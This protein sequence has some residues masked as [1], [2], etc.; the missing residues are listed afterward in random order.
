MLHGH[1]EYHLLR[2]AEVIEETADSRSFVLEIP[3]ALAES[4][5]YAAGQFCTF[6]ATIDGAEVVRSY[7]MSSSPDVDEP[8]TTTVKRVP[9][10]LM[11]NWMIDKVG[12]G[13]E[14][15][16]MRPAGLFTLGDHETP[17]VCFAGGSGIT[18]VISVI[19]SALAKTSRLISLIYANRSREQVIFSKGLEELEQR[20]G[21]RLRLHHHLDQATGFLDE[22]ACVELIGE[23][24]DADFYVCGPTP[25]MDTVESALEQVGIS[26]GQLFIERFAAPAEVVALNE[27]S[28]TERVTFKIE[29]KKKTVDYR[30]GDT[31]LETARRSGGRPPSSCE[32]GNCG[33]CMALVEKGVATMR[34]NNALTP[35]E[36]E[37]GW[38]L[39]CQAIPSS[40]EI[41]VN[42][43]A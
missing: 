8:L 2:V 11:S 18:P 24:R 30:L 1:E 31:L 32:A 6:R 29:R 21:G 39:T 16:V 20:A 27:A 19:K 13:D 4:F 28:A 43:D 7:S 3:A 23:Q 14:L 12:V 40:L 26:P 15:E 36:V 9:G 41:T 22:A 10:G 37:E 33:T 17:I 38:V 25:F 5:A 35:A 34:A 42:Y